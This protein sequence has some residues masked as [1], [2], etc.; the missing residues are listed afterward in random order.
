MMVPPVLRFK[1]GPKRGSVRMYRIEYIC[2]LQDE[3]KRQF[4]EIFVLHIF[5]FLGGGVKHS[6]LLDSV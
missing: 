5:F 4:N 6:I 2:F 3:L 1:S